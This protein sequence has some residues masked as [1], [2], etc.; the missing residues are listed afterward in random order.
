[1][2]DMVI[3]GPSATLAVVRYIVPFNEI[4]VEVTPEF[5]AELLAAQVV[6]D[7]PWMFGARETPSHIV[8]LKRGIFDF[9]RK[10]QFDYNAPEPATKF[11]IKE[12]PK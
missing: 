9:I 7:L 2:S 4:H 12:N 8:R 6:T 10:A 1:M 11:F 5:A 3:S